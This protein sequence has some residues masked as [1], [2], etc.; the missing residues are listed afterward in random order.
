MKK[1]GWPPFGAMF[2]CLLLGAAAG[3]QA[4]EEIDTGDW[5]NLFDGETTFGW[6]AVGPDTWEVQDGNLTASGGVGSTMMTNSQFQD[7]ELE[8]RVRV[9]RPGTAGILVRSPLSGHPSET[10]AG[11]ILVGSPEEGDAE[12][13]EVTVRAVGGDVEATVNGEPVE[14]FRANQ[15]IGHIGIAYHAYHGMR[16]H[17]ATVE[18]TD[19]RLRP[20]RLKSIF[21]GE[22]LD[23]WN[24]IPDRASIFTVADGVMNIR[25]GNGQ[26]ETAGVYQ[27]FL[28]QMDIISHGEHLNSGVFFRG[29]VGVF[30]RGYE[31]QVRNQWE[32][33]DRTSPVDFG[34][35]GIYGVQEARKVVSTDHEWFE[36][37]IIVNGNHFAVWVDGYQVADMF[38]MRPIHEGAD[39][40]NGFVPDAGT[41]HLQG[42]DPGT[43]LSFRDMH[44]QEYPE[45]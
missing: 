36:K 26:I 14:G 6:S 28:L 33:D 25:D 20:L 24:I 9:S 23:G 4:F 12:W 42:H 31:S 18:V 5:I 30:W 43:D 38:D 13:Q 40:K 11:M 32:G 35:G 22:N 2:A 3:A 44:I 1:T 45:S 15:G 16:Q 41:I 21:N 27:N 8:L 39:G 7:F 37:T 17:P 19:V 29:P 10:G 34:T